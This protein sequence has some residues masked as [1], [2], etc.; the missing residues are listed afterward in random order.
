M[1]VLQGILGSAGVFGRGDVTKPAAAAFLV[2]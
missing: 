1:K 2:D